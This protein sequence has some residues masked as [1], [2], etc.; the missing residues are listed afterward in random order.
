MVRF[1]NTGTDTAFRVIVIDT[2][3]EKLDIS[4][5]QLGSS[6]HPYTFDVVGKDGRPVLIFTFEDIYLPDSTTDEVNSNGFL[7]FKISPDSLL[8]KGSII[9]NEADIYFDFNLP[10]TTNNAWVTIYDTTLTGPSIQVEEIPTSINDD[11]YP[12]IPLTVS[13]NPFIDGFS[14][15]FPKQLIST[16]ATLTL[17]DALGKVLL[18][19][20]VNDK[21][22]VA[23]E[24]T[25][26]SPGLYFIELTTRK[27]N[28]GRTKII[29]Q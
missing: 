9:N 20:T 7:K 19:K 23:F 17:F 6:S 22:E 26:L 1:Q 25:R 5:L 11:I 3:S 16:G 10:I 24:G 12:A 4:T 8:E 18:I 2:L 28:V 21:P 13:P 15:S 14:V 27:G 29:K